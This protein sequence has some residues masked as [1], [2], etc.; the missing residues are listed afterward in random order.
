MD[1]YVQSKKKLALLRARYRQAEQKRRRE[2]E[3]REARDRI[4]RKVVVFLGILC[5][6]MAVFLLCY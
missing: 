1:K 4:F 2:E 5:S 6:A 3:A